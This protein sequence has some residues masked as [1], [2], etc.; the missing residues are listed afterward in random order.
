[1]S[2]V[3]RRTLLQS[4]TGAGLTV[5]GATETHRL[6]TQPRGTGAAADPVFTFASLPDFFNGDVG[7]L[8]GLPTWDLGLNSINDSWRAAIDHCLGAMSAHQPDAVFLAGD[9]VEGHWNMDDDDRRI[10]GPVSRGI[11]AE[12]IDMC[13]AAITSAS[14]VYYPFLADLFSSRG[15]DL[16]PAVGDHEILD[17]RSGPLN[18]RWSPSGFHKGEPDNRYYLVKHCKDVWSDHFTRVGGEPRFSRRPRGTASEFTAYAVS[19]AD[20]LTL[21]NVDVFMHHSQGVRL[22]VFHGQL[23]W[24]RDEIRRAKR[25]GHTVVVQGHIPVM[26]PTRWLASGKLHVPEA[27]AS[28]MYHVLDREGADVYLCG[29]VHDNTAIQRDRRAPVQISHGCIFRYGFSYLVGRLYPD[30]RL[31][32]DLYEIPLERASRSTEIWSTARARRQHTVLEFGDPVHRGRLVQRHR[33]V[34]RR[35]VKLGR[36][37]ARHDPYSNR[38]HNTT[39]YF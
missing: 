31:V 16:Y 15:L 10:F 21:I 7:D 12:S 27:R 11:D 38:L 29:E 36:Y 5:A 8:S 39:V 24:L 30:H 35:T 28:A 19:F 25:R 34:L 4:V 1:M 17:D 3:T 37:D 6:V 26:R 18:D 9:M 32:L 13:N 23:R 20:S 22:G 2:P 33:E 14:G